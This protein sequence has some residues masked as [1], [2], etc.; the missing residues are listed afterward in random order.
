MR[1]AVIQADHV[2]LSSCGGVGGGAGDVHKLLPVPK[3]PW[4]SLQTLLPLLEELG[5]K[6]TETKV[7]ESGRQHPGKVGGHFPLWSMSMAHAAPGQGA[8]FP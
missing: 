7:N 1:A 5:L 4:V 2:L 3:Y 8:A 6:A